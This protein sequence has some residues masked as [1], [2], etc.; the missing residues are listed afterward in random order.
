MRITSQGYRQRKRPAAT[1]EKQHDPFGESS[2]V[3]LF[4]A[5]SQQAESARRPDRHTP[6]V[7]SDPTVAVLV[8][9][10]GA[11]GAGGV[12]RGAGVDAGSGGAGGGAH[13]PGAGAGTPR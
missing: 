4:F 12:A 2:T 13:P 9:L 1:L 5:C 7:W 6:K 8:F 3:R 10:A 11:A